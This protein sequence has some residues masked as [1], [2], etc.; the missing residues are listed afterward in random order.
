MICCLAQCLHA[1][2]P[3]LRTVL[4]SQSQIT[5]FS[6]LSK[7]SPRAHLLKSHRGLQ[8]LISTFY[9]PHKEGNKDV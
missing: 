1:I 4:K 9:R 3:Q 7:M 5:A 2:F 8:V 6:L